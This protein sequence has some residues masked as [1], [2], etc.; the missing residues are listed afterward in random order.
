[1]PFSEKLK[2]EIKERAHFKCCLCREQLVNHVHHIIP[3][4]KGGTDDEENAAPLCGTCH[5]QYGNNPDMRKFIRQSRDF[6]YKQ[7][8]KRSQP[9]FGMLSEI[10]ERISKD[11]VTKEDLQ[12]AVGKLENQLQQIINQPISTS[13]KL[14]RISD[15]T[16]VATSAFTSATCFSPK[17]HCPK[18]GYFYDDSENKNCPKC[19]FPNSG[20]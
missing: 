14:I 15:A 9:D 19:D 4:N 8:E 11:I 6:W 13:E 10:H 5:F 18:C 17:S 1:M 2:K 7:C 20:F 12:N 16:N 3:E